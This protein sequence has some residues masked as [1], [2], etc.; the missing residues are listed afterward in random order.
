MLQLPPAHAEPPMHV[1]D[2]GTLALGGMKVEGS[3]RKDDQQRGA[4]LLLGFSPVTNLE[5]S[6]AA[7]RDR[8]TAVHPASL[9]YGTGIGAKWVPI[10]RET[11]WSLGARLDLGRTRINARSV[12]LKYYEHEVALNGLATF[13]SE[14]GQVVHLSLGAT[15]VSALGQ[16]DTQTTWGA[17]FEQPLREKL[18][19]IAEI[20]GQEHGGAD[21]AIGL[22]F[23]VIE[24]FKLSAILGRGNQRNFAQA[25]FA[26]EF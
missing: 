24:G 21:K 16:H 18:T 23:E 11:G 5:L 12:P 1:D 2:A 4:E 13:R 8:D 26:W 6:V 9:L 7:A 10:Q 20:Y 3:W 15:R 14:G 17:G 22:R 25:G 19:L